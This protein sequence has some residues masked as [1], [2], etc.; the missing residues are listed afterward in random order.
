MISNKRGF[1]YFYLLLQ[2]TRIVLIL[3][4]LKKYTTN[5]WKSQYDYISKY[6]SY[7]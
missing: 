2:S 5:G 1:S 3:D 7:V 6:L 4:P